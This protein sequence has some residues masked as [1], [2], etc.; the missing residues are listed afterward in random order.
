M[1]WRMEKRGRKYI[2][3]LLDFRPQGNIRPLQDLRQQ[4][5]EAFC[6]FVYLMNHIKVGN[7]REEEGQGLSTVEYFTIKATILDIL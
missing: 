4:C 7:D 6:F 1:E 2:Q 5:E 3:P